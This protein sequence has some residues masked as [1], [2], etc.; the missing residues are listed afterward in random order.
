MKKWLWAIVSLTMLGLAAA[1][2]FLLPLYPNVTE[3][4]VSRGLFRL[5]AFPLEWLVS[6]VPFS[7]TEAALVLGIPAAVVLVT[8]WVVRLVR[9]PDRKRRLLRAARFVSL[10]L[11]AAVLVY[12]VTFGAGYSRHTVEQLMDLPGRQYTPEELT[13]VACDLAAKASAAREQVAENA[14][15]HMVLSAG[16][17]ATL[18]QSNNIYDTLRQDYPFLVTGAH[19]AKPVLLSHL[20]SYTGTTGMYTPWLGESNINID[21]PHC[22]IGHT[23]AHETAHTMGFGHEKECNFLGY[24]ACITSGNP[25]YVYSGYLLAYIYCGNELYHTDRQAWAESYKLCSA[26]VRRDLSQR[27]D[28]WDQFRGEVMESA[29]QSNDTFIKVNGDSDGVRSY[30]R[31][32][33]LILAYYDK[34]G[35]I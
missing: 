31:V 23:I 18:A 14:E 26:G 1:M 35:V 13:A 15:G 27:D 7:L 4:V 22:D 25:D 19:R 28:Y 20:W 29:Q 2:Y 10:T 6:L 5:V 3:A 17:Q 33:E 32:V 12:M 8:V 16:I 34:I 24:L 21:G 11:S 30:D 9:R